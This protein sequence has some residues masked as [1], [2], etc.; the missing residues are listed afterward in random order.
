MITVIILAFFGASGLA[1]LIVFAACAASGR[2]D[3]IQREAFGQFYN[4]SEQVVATAEKQ[5]VGNKQLTLNPS[6]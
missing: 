6:I 5:H 2:A 4:E 1:S 3:Q